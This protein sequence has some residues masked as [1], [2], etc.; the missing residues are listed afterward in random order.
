MGRVLSVTGGVL[1]AVSAIIALI[2]LDR[3]DWEKVGEATFPWPL[4]I[5]L[6]ALLLGTYSY[7]A[8]QR[9]WRTPGPMT[10]WVGVSE[11]Q[12]PLDRIFEQLPRSVVREIECEDFGG[13]WRED[14]T[15]PL[16][17]F[18]HEFD[19]AENEFATEELE[20]RRRKLFESAKQLLIEEA[21]KGWD[22]KMAD[23]RRNVGWTDLEISEDFEKLKLARGRS[24]AIYAAAQ[25]F[26]AAHDAFARTA[27][28]HGLALKLDGDPPQ[29]PWSEA[30]RIPN[31]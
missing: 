1:S 5:V 29:P 23:G 30:G 8:Y 4:V 24:D 12:A 31:A 17:P 7:L 15:W 16:N 25:E 11:D 28:K 2:V 20:A 27:K 22:H 10:G 3:S 26:S 13:S 6:A 18:V 9:F 21:G 19:G 14:L